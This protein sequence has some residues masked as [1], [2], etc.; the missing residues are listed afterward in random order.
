MPPKPLSSMIIL[1]DDRL[2]SE[3][4]VLERIAQW[5]PD[6]GP[7][8]DVRRIE[9]VLTF[10]V[11]EER[12]VV[13][14]MPAAIPWAD[15]AGPC[16]AA[17]YWPQAGA[18][19]RDQAAHLLVVFLS[20]D[21]D[22][23]NASLRF[24]RLLAALTDSCNAAGVFWGGGGLVHEPAV[25]VAAARDSSRQA[26]PL[27]LWIG[28]NLG[29]EDD[30]TYS[31]YTSGMEAFGQMEI[32]VLHSCSDPKSLYDRIRDVTHYAL[33]RNVIIKDGDTV[34]ASQGERI[35]MTEGP[36]M[37]DGTTTVIQLAL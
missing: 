32:E 6:L 7:I 13:S 19:L 25:F 22:R 36:S 24:T 28:Y 10:D 18:K 12:L 20:A 2:P 37:C 9:N 3:A 14:L 15:L 26:L 5:W 34:G 1:R 30:G 27:Q 11:D 8:G 29:G 35:E 4:D 21:A 31:L 33:D 17:W 16:S 23:T